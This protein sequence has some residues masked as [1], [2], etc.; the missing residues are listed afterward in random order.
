MPTKE[1][2]RQKLLENIARIQQ[3]IPDFTMTEEQINQCISDQ[4]YEIFKSLQGKKKLQG[5]EFDKEKNDII[6]QYCDSLATHKSFARNIG[7]MCKYENTEEDKAYNKELFSNLNRDDETGE[8]ARDEYIKRVLNVPF[9][10]DLDFLLSNPSDE[11][12]IAYSLAHEDEG[13]IGMAFSSYIDQLGTSVKYKDPAAMK[14]FGLLATSFGTYIQNIRSLMESEYYMSMPLSYMSEDQFNRFKDSRDKFPGYNEMIQSGDTSL[15]DLMTFEEMRRILPSDVQKFKEMNYKPWTKSAYEYTDPKEIRI[16]GGY[17]KRVQALISACDMIAGLGEEVAANKMQSLKAAAA[18]A[19]TLFSALTD[20]PDEQT[21]KNLAKATFDLSSSIHSY[22]KD[23]DVAANEDPQFKASVKELEN[24]MKKITPLKTE[25]SLKSLVRTER[26]DREKILAW[27]NSLKDTLKNDPELNLDITKPTD[28]ISIKTCDFKVNEDTVSIGDPTEYKG[29]LS[30]AFIPKNLSADDHFESYNA[31]DEPP[32]PGEEGQGE[33]IQTVDSYETA[34][35]AY[36]NKVVQLEEAYKKNAAPEKLDKLEKELAEAKKERFESYKRFAEANNRVFGAKHAW[37]LKNQKQFDPNNKEDYKQIKYLYQQAEKGLL[38]VDL[39]SADSE[40]K[41]QIG[42]NT[43]T[44]NAEIIKTR[45]AHAARPQ[46]IAAVFDALKNGEPKESLGHGAEYY[47]F[48]AAHYK[49]FEKENGTDIRFL[50]NFVGKPPVRPVEVAKPGALSWFKRIISFG[51]ANG[52]FKK[53][54]Q[55]ERDLADYN[56]KAEEYPRRKE[57]ARKKNLAS[58]DGVI[59]FI[60]KYSKELGMQAPEGVQKVGEVTENMIRIHYTEENP[61]ELSEEYEAKGINSSMLRMEFRGDAAFRIEAH[62]K[63]EMFNQDGTIKEDASK[64]YWDQKKEIQKDDALNGVKKVEDKLSRAREDWKKRIEEKAK[65]QKLEEAKQLQ[66]EM[67]E[68]A[69]KNAEAEK[70][71]TE[72]ALTDKKNAL[73]GKTE[74]IKEQLEDLKDLDVPKEMLVKVST[75]WASKPY[76]DYIKDIGK[77]FTDKPEELWEKG[78][79][80]LGILACQN[81]QYYADGSE[82][83]FNILKT[84]SE[85]LPEVN[86]L[87]DL[88]NHPERKEANK[89]LLDKIK[90]AMA[91]PNPSH[92][93]N[94]AMIIDSMSDIAFHELIINGGVNQF[95]GDMSKVSPGLFICAGLARSGIRQCQKNPNSNFDFREGFAVHNDPNKPPVSIA[96]A[97]E[98]VLE[99]ADKCAN[100]R[101][102]IGKLNKF[103][104]EYKEIKEKPLEV[105]P[106]KLTIKRN[107]NID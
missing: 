41:Y 23:K 56:R 14:Q 10:Y 69:K 31:E 91:D 105:E 86:T 7:H 21:I 90:N 25:K 45:G 93:E 37:S 101:V 36:G 100:I 61:L 32:Y 94:T 17:E 81:Q 89:A 30:Y 59:K 82:K 39:A 2:L 15:N 57:E 48:I 27:Y 60:N 11:E 4:K 74:D 8:E 34:F 72:N 83:P 92:K 9:N 3:V 80:A 18:N 85:I 65:Q 22:I 71:A 68:I 5:P 12:L 95:A 26:E 75:G 33:I 38:Y 70:I 88:S 103:T 66:N 77:L 46:V 13:A 84:S 19:K 24:S 55:Y 40:Q 63:P 78:V 62:E 1:E 43:N 53:Y 42:V 102:A 52:D 6:D 99:F 96:D 67:K 98:T 79:Q 58:Y 104:Q 51:F 107:L 28:M 106:E 35:N 44:K 50:A 49:E 87:I 47:D 97:R 16:A 54:D 20:F 76:K 73:Y 64:E 29:S